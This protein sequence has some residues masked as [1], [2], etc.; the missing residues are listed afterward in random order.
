MEK[1]EIRAGVQVSWDEENGFVLWVEPTV[2]AYN[3][4][5]REALRLYA[6]LSRTFDKL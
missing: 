1:I 5:E 4:T 2:V 3:L 6:F